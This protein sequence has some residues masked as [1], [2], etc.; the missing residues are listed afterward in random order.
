[1]RTCLPLEWGHLFTISMWHHQ[2]QQQAG[3][4]VGQGR[5]ADGPQASPQCGELPPWVSEADRSINPLMRSFAV[6]EDN[7]N[8]CEADRPEGVTPGGVF[9]H[10]ILPPF[11]EGRFWRWK[12]VVT[13]AARAGNGGLPAQLGR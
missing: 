13:S 6:G 5:S 1:M 3:R 4:P 12:E 7:K 8:I 9:L 10:P 11:F 2:Q